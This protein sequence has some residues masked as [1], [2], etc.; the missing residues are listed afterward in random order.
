MDNDRYSLF[1]VPE[2]NNPMLSFTVVFNTVMVME[3]CQIQG[4]EHCDHS[5]VTANDL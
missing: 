1:S 5:I 2:N 4:S 3:V